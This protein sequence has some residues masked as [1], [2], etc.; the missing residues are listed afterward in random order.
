M[1]DLQVIPAMDLMDGHCV[2][3]QGGDFS[4]RT[5]YSTD[6]LQV[7]KAF[8]EAG[9]TRLHMVDLDGA[10]SGSPKHL[11]TLKK[12]AAATSL[13]IDYSGGIKTEENIQSVFANGAGLVAIGSVAVRNKPLF[14][15]WIDRYG[16]EKI[17]LGVD[18]R[19]EQLAIS[20]WLEQTDISLFDF[21]SE[22][23][24]QGVRQ[25][26]C[27]DI[28]KDGMMNGPSLT[29]YKKIKHTFPDLELIASGGVS[30]P[31]QLADLAT[32]GCS[33]AI[34]G[35]AIYEDF[36]QLSKWLD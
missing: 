16:P 14:F 23:V 20:G 9:F 15:D 6:P 8:A 3:L 11:A 30:S 18:V 2:R 27:T 29:L 10:R 36:G 17:L 12:I 19:N 26:F 34:V 35:K 25:V 21:L 13:I 1:N 7:A 32:I 4:K 22:M 28:G 31:G 24:Q 5:D 33:G